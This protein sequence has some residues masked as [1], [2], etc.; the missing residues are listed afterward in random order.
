LQPVETE[1]PRWPSSGSTAP[2]APEQAPSWHGIALAAVAVFFFA[3]SPILV[4]WAAPLNAFE[5]TAGRLGIAA[6]VV[7]LMARLSGQPLLPRR[8]D[9]PLFATIALITALHF[10]TYIASLS[11]TTI[12]HA[13]AIVYTAPIFVAIFSALILKEPIASRKWVGVIITVLGIAVLAGFE[14]RLNQR[15]IVG[16]LLAL[17]CAIT[18]GLYSVAGRSQRERYGLLTYAGTVYALACL[19]ALPA[20]LLTFSTAGVT[21]R[22]ILALV[23]AGLLPQALGHTMYNAS[24]RRTNATVVNLVATQEVVGGII[25]GAVLLGQIPQTNEIVGAAIALGGIVLVLVS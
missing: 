16:D 2:T 24:L 11:F 13:L 22:S 7:W 23:L 4:F 21:P 19:W 3:T 15:M 14:P 1:P 8:A 18:F 5:I 25:L 17:V 6:A 9:L 20:A 10:L 12:A